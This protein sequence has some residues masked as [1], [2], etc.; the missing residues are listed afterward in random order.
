MVPSAKLAKARMKKKYV[1]G[2]ANQSA[3]EMPPEPGLPFS[4]FEL[5]SGRRKLS[6]LAA[7]TMVRYRLNFSVDKNVLSLDK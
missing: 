5:S 2:M 7:P 6:K 4:V 3:S 1:N